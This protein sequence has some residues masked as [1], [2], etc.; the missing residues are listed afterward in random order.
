MKKVIMMAMMLGFFT[1]LYSGVNEL[2][3]GYEHITFYVSFDGAT[4]QAFYPATMKRVSASRGTFRNQLFPS[5]LEIPHNTKTITIMSGD[6]KDI[7][8]NDA[9]IDSK[10]SANIVIN[11]DHTCTVVPI[12]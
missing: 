11:L 10:H 4:L 5:T 12:Y 6:G 7:L 3:N 9:P 8:L 2:M 1:G